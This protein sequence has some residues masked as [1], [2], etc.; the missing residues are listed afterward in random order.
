VSGIVKIVIVEDEIRIREGIIKLLNKYYTGIERV[1][2][3]KSGEEGL[4]V[5]RRFEPD[6]VITDIRM[7]PIDGLEMLQIL[8]EKEKMTFRTIIL[9]AYSEFN[10]AKQGIKLG[11]FDYLVK[12]VD[13]NEF[14]KTMQRIMDKIAEEKVLR[15]ETSEKLR[16]FED[17]LTGIISG[18]QVYNDD[19]E[20]F[21]EKTYGIFRHSEI[22]LIC[23]YLGKNS[24]DDSRTSVKRILA[25]LTK[26]NYTGFH[27]DF[28]AE[29]NKLFFAITGSIDNIEKHL[30]C[31]VIREV[32]GYIKKSA[33]IAFMICAGFEKIIDSFKNLQNILDWAVSLGGVNVI[34]HKKI[35]SIQ[36]YEF[37][38]PINIE[39]AAI[40]AICSMD[41]MHIN[42]HACLFLDSIDV[43][44]YNPESIKKNV[45]RYLLAVLAV[46]KEVNFGAY[47]KMNESEITK[48]VAEAVTRNEIKDIVYEFMETAMQRG[49]LQVSQLQNGEKTFSL[50][51]QKALRMIDEFYMNGIN[52]S[53]VAFAMNITPEHISSLFTKELG[54]NFSTYIKDF[55]LKKAKEL[56]LGTNL[57]LFEIAEQTGYSDAK[58]FSRVFKDTQGVLPTEYRKIHR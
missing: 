52:L 17:V 8:I 10:Y 33:V 25:S 12:P 16:S 51:V 54:V 57:K 47:K 48:A 46:V 18:R 20:K 50:A 13:I 43:K 44:N 19:L 6:V 40:E 53:E 29:E 15:Q 35:A 23:V 30:E 49:H 28:P 2:E 3:A 11:I 14:R 9:S 36:H 31:N 34:S 26:G 32:H 22:A 55:K 7:E 56:L 58:Y 38:Y 39:K 1:Y 42:K 45:I 41:N 5:I 37:V 4:E 27:I 21:I 24:T